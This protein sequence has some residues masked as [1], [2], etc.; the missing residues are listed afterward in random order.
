MKSIIHTKQ[1]IKMFSQ[2]AIQSQYYKEL[3]GL[4][5]KITDRAADTT[6]YDDRESALE[7]TS[8]L[9]D[10]VITYHMKNS[11]TKKAAN[12]RQQSR[13]SKIAEVSNDN[14]KNINKMK[15]IVSTIVSLSLV[16][17]AVDA[18]KKKPTKNDLRKITQI[19]SN[20]HAYK[21]HEA[22]PCICNKRNL[23]THG[24]LCT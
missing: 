7:K 17:T 8:A 23:E 1:T 19:H 3:F 14:R 24:C 16:E 21:T 9:D 6:E 22:C 18:I 20:K 10:F 12:G 4:H 13:Q 2:H 5:L 15:K 11:K